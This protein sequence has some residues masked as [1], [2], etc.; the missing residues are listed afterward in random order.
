MFFAKD[1]FPINPAADGYTRAAV[2]NTSYLLS[3]LFKRPK[4]KATKNLLT[5]EAASQGASPAAADGASLKDTAQSSRLPAGDGEVISYWHPAVAVRLVTD[6]NPM[7]PSMLPAGM[8][9]DVKFLHDE[10]GYLP[11]TYINDF[12][13][14]RENMYPINET[15]PTLPLNITVGPISLVGALTPLVVV[16]VQPPCQLPAEH[17]QVNQGVV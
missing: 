16:L 4:I 15:T 6:Q 5:G 7:R 10:V 2:S 1:G 13:D 11:A 17:I 8:L 12:W 3:R 14:L 9:S